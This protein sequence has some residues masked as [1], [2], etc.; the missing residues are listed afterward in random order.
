MEKL[1]DTIKIIHA[2]LRGGEYRFLADYFRLV[3]SHVCDC[4]LKRDFTQAFGA[5]IVIKDGLDPQDLEKLK[6]NYPDA[7]LLSGIELSTA[8]EEQKK[9][10]LENCLYSIE[11]NQVSSDVSSTHKEMEALKKIA[12][13]FVQYKLSEAGNTFNYFYDNA[14]VV[15]EAQDRYVDAIL[16]LEKDKNFEDG[17]SK[18]YIYTRVNLARTI[19]ETCSFLNQKLLFDTEKCMQALDKALTLDSTFAN[20]YVLKGFLNE[21][22]P[23]Y[24]NNCGSY[25]QKAIKEIGERPYTSYLYYRLGRF[26]EKVKKDWN[27][28]EIYYRKSIE[29]NQDTYRAIYKIMLIERKEKKYIEAIE[30]C[31]RIRNILYEKSSNNYLQRKEYEYLIK[32][33]H[34]E[35]VIY[36]KYLHDERKASQAL[37]ERDNLCEKIRMEHN[38]MYSQIYGSNAKKFLDLTYEKFK[39]GLR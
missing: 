22:D 35:W 15:Q 6:E 30:S 16:D 20:V 29:M 13:V 21:I 1:I 28:A 17:Q 8:T 31:K 14:E 27:Q 19:N 34:N 10:Y 25:Y 4:T 36:G 33:Y 3:G 39:L 38:E 7:V 32:A 24:K 26:Y 37:S 18:Y 5:V 11:R 2:E 9:E 12:S 23:R